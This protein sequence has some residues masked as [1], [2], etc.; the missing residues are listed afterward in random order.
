VTTI[1][2]PISDP[3]VEAILREWNLRFEL[4][5]AVEIGS[6]IQVSEQ[7]ARAVAHRAIPANVE[8]Y[9]EHMKNGAQFPPIVLREPRI[10]LDGNTRVQAATKL[11]MQ[12]FPAYVVHDITTT[13][14]ARALSAAINQ[15]NGQPLTVEEAQE[16]AIE[17][18]YGELKFSVGTVARYVGR[19]GA[20]I[21]RWRKQAEVMR[22]A[23][24]LGIE[25]QATRISATQR[26]KLAGVQFDEPFRRLVEVVSDSKPPNAELSTVVKDIENASSEHEAVSL[27]EAAAMQ[28]RPTGP[29]GRVIRNEKA[30]RA[31]MLA[32]QLLNLRAADLFDPEKGVDDRIMWERLRDHCDDVLRAFITHGIRS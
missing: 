27:V 18:L 20:Q 24:R 21:T 30:R 16:I 17:M 23:E 29:S 14:M 26:E 15:L 5:E 11:G 31:R 7:Q 22:H 25:E 6:I 10:M 32:P 28:W 2:R 9:Y 4:L 1:I 13:D 19:S 12:F 3:K 8:R